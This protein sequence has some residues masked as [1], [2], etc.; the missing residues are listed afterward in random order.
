MTKARDEYERLFRALVACPDR[1]SPEA[2]SICDE[3][4]K[5][6][7]KLTEAEQAEMRALAASL[8]E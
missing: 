2:E 1:D 4:D 7:Y 6:W 8:Q 5:W 3:S